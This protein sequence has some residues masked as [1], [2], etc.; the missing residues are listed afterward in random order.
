VQQYVNDSILW[1]TRPGQE[2]CAIARYP[3]V[4]SM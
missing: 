2:W 3:L 1:D 4:F